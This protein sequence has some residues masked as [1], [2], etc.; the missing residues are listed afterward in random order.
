[1]NALL[2]AISATGKFDLIQ[3]RGHK[4][5]EEMEFPLVIDDKLQTLKKSSQVMEVLE[6]LGLNLELK[7]VKEGKQIRAGKG[8]RR[9]RKYKR[10]TGPLIVI[11]DDFGIFKAARNIPGVDVINVNELS[12]KLLAPGTHPGRLVLWTQSAF[13]QLKKFEVN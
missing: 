3:N 8:K 9:G 11:K 1:M 7:R 2:S 4:I 13:Q 10:K 5:T 6:K 12:C